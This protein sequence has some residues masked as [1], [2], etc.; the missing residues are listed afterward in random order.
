MNDVDDEL[1][2]AL[3]ELTGN[4]NVQFHQGQREAIESLALHH[5]RLV[6]VQRTGWGKSA[7]YFVATHLLRKGGFGPTLLISPLLALMRNQINAAERL[8]LRAYTISSASEN[9]VTELVALLDTDSV[10]LVVISPERLAN[11]AFA[12]LVMPL[13]GRRPGLTVVDEVHCISDW[14]HDFRPDYRRI[15]KMLAV[16]PKG[17]PIL[18]CTATAN[19]RVMEDAREQLGQDA[20]VQRGPLGRQGLALSVLELPDQADRLAWLSMNV[21]RLPGSGIIY[22]LTTRDVD[23]VTAW[24]MQGGIDARPYY[25][26]VDLEQ[27]EEAER[28]LLEGNLKVLVATNALGMGYDNARIGF[29]VH[30]QSPGSVVHYYQQ[31]GRAGR[32]LVNSKGILLAGDED[33]QIIE[34]FIDSAF[35]T[36]SQVTEVLAVLDEAE[37]PL[38]LSSISLEVNLKWTQIENVLKQLDVAGAVRRVKAQTYERTLGQWIY[39]RAHVEELSR[40]RHQELE[41][42]Q[43]Y[44]EE[45]G[46]RM[47]FLVRALDDNVL[48]DCGLCDNCTSERLPVALDA[49]LVQKAKEFLDSQFGIIKPRKKDRHRKIIPEAQ[50]VAQG[51]YLCRWGDAGF[52]QM[53]RRGK[54]EDAKFDDALVNALA[55]LLASW[56][57]TPRPKAITFVPSRN[58]PELVASLARRLAGRLGLE[59]FDILERTRYAE[60][61]KTMLNSAHQAA[62]VDGAFTLKGTVA[63][64][65]ELGPVILL[66]DIVDSRWTMTEIGRVLRRA[67][68]SEVYPL[69][70]ATS[71]P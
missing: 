44:A 37:A 22:C 49:E 14:G 53:V 33:E 12:D 7:V 47:T 69:A 26:A 50:R 65:V 63:L 45:E 9:T 64:P 2:E 19:D 20:I 5:Q 34:W 32:A 71:A 6:L 48:I 27:K 11:P 70:L 42:M 13:I 31:V 54:Q 15:G 39:P 66:D 25:K 24:L 38:S 40:I 55:G 35:P 59:F 46:C 57:P 36:E 3:R 56:E 10:D 67:G 62:N 16:F 58:H 41:E 8:G 18:G 23:V 21:N 17:M 29:V 60:P 4:R 1:L 61:Q 68:F 51:R 52:G 43:H 28:L 30:Y